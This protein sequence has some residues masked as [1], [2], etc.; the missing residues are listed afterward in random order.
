MKTRIRL[1]PSIVIIICTLI[2]IGLATWLTRSPQANE[3]TRP[4]RTIARPVD[5][6]FKPANKHRLNF[7][8][9]TQIGSVGFEVQENS[10]VV[11]NGS[12]VSATYKVVYY[13]FAKDTPATISDPRMN[14]GCISAQNVNFQQDSNI[15][16][17]G[18]YGKPTAGVVSLAK[19]VAVAPYATTTTTFTVNGLCQFIGTQDGTYW[20]DMSVV[21]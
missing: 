6:T 8:D 11:N 9:V 5:T 1:H 19:P 14:V 18:A 15:F 17:Y 16:T 13:D 20:W 21:Q 2:L 7:D 10:S 12:M 4:Q 3:P